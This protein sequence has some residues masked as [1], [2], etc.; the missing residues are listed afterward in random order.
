[1]VV[2]GARWTAIQL[3]TATE[4]HPQRKH[5][6]RCRLRPRWSLQA[7]VWF[8]ALASLELLVVSILDER[9][10]WFYL[11]L[12]TLPLAAAFLRR[13]QRNLQSILIVFL[14]EL[15]EDWKLSRVQDSSPAPPTS[16][17]PA[18]PPPEPVST[19]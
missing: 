15:A 8:W 4:D 5:L 1:V 7:K 18:T 9:S 3:T 16:P 13:E 2:Y 12:L 10:R 17:S 6:I 14:N 11:L 19:R